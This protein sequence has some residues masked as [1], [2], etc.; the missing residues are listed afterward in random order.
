MASSKSEQFPSLQR[1]TART[2][3]TGKV[4]LGDGLISE[5][6]PTLHR[7]TKKT[8]DSG[9]VRMGDGLISDEFPV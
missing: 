9:K 6:F 8:T 4:R 3:D 2:A 5:E 1:E 7:Q